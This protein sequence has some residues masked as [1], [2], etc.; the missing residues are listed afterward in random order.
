VIIIFGSSEELKRLERV[1][2]QIDRIESYVKGN[3]IKLDAIYTKE[4]VMSQ[5]VDNIVAAVEAEKTVVDS[6]IVLLDQISAQIRDAQGDPDK[7]AAIAAGID[8][9]KQALA[10]AVVRNTPGAPPAPTE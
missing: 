5:Q 3:S 7:L 10:E 6:A 1:M 2:G 8:A 9:Q 4:T